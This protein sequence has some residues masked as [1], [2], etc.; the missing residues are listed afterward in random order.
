MK[1]AVTEQKTTPTAT[2][3]AVIAMRVGMTLSLL[4]VVTIV[5]DQA[6][7]DNLTRQLQGLY[8]DPGKV[9]MAKSSILTYLFAINAVGVI[10]WLWLA[11]AAK[12]GKHW[13]RATTTVVFVLATAISCYNFTQPHP[14]FVTLVGV[15]PCIA[16]LATVVLLWQRDSLSSATSNKAIA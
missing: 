15:L 12:N 13:T 2:G 5:V 7:G 10:S 14:F 3:K 16:G 11:W 9:D 8:S 4:A 1:S 6:S